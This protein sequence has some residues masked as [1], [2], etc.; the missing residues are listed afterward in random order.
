MIGYP[1]TARTHRGNKVVRTRQGVKFTLE[2][3]WNARLG[4]V[5]IEGVGHAVDCLQVHDYDWATGTLTA[6]SRKEIALAFEEYLG[7]NE[8]SLIENRRWL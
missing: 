3:D 2:F 8:A 4:E 7:D 5:W 6:R 1:R